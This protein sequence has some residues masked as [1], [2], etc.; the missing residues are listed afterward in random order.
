MQR[1][2]IGEM[3]IRGCLSLL[4]MGQLMGL[5]ID[6]YMLVFSVQC[7]DIDAQFA[8]QYLEQN[9][10]YINRF[11]VKDMQLKT[12]GEMV[13]RGRLSLFMMGQLMGLTIAQYMLVFSVQSVDI[14]AQLRVNILG[15]MVDTSIGLVLRICSV[16]RQE[17][18]SSEAVSR[19]LL[20]V[21]VQSLLMGFVL[22]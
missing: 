21:F 9:G 6:Q 14:D 1:Q 19:C 4:M 17:R 10:Q 11:G 7:V 20:D 18:W 22:L 2:T 3:V 5:T 8:C 15:K 13:I 16:R 12:A